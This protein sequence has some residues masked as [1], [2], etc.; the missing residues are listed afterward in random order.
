MDIKIAKSIHKDLIKNQVIDRDHKFGDVIEKKD[1]DGFHSH[2]GM[3]HNYREDIESY[4]SIV[5]RNK[6]EIV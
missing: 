4:N 2:S 1:I 5:K 6:D 3:D